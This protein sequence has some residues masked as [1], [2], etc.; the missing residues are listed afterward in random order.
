LGAKSGPAPPAKTFWKKRLFS[1][2]PKISDILQ[3]S[4]LYIANQSSNVG[5][6]EKELICTT[7]LLAERVCHI[8]GPVTNL[9][10]DSYDKKRFG[11]KRHSLPWRCDE[12][13]HRGYSR[14]SYYMPCF[15]H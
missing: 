4:Q 7:P 2:C 6:V 3:P 13:V 10:H 9:S 12:Q 8:C 5:T 1:F 15:E 11:K 14:S